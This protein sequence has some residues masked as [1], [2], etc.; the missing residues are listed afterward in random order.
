V[1]VAVRKLPGVDS[2]EVS[3][4]RGVATIWL[5]PGNAIRVAAIREAIRDNGFTPKAA[6]VKVQGRIVVTEGRS[7]LESGASTWLLNPTSPGVATALGRAAGRRVRIDGL[8]PET[9][10]RDPDPTR[11]EVGAPPQLLPSAPTMM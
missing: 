5:A 7:W 10:A 9:S 6:E 8:V 4:N 11:L 2:V 3:L 1:R